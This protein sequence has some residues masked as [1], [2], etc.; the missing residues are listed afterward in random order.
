MG[1]KPK[2]PSGQSLEERVDKDGGKGNANFHAALFGGS[3]DGLSKA[4]LEEQRR[5]KQGKD[6]P[7]R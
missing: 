7:K 6:G 2:K 3:K 4:Q 5:Q 1:F